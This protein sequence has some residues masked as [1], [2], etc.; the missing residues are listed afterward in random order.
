[1]SDLTEITQSANILNEADSVQKT[2]RAP[3]SWNILW[4]DIVFNRIR[5]PTNAFGATDRSALIR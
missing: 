2:I 1:M 3:I 4:A 5:F